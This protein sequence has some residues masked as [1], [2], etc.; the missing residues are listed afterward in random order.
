[1]VY[2]KRQIIVP[3]LE[4]SQHFP[5]SEITGKTMSSD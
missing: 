4:G 3:W 5:K 1:M 2:G